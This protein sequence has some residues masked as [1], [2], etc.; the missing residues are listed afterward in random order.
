MVRQLKEGGAASDCFFSSMFGGMSEPPD[1]KVEGLSTQHFG[2][3]NH[4]APAPGNVE[5]NRLP[6]RVGTVCGGE[7]ILYD[8]I[9]ELGTRREEAIALQEKDRVPTTHL[10]ETFILWGDL[11]PKRSAPPESASHRKRNLIM[12]HTIDIQ[13]SAPGA[14]RYARAAV[15]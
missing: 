6:G 8:V 4:G 3:P 7:P 2:V 10:E 1:E 9:D 5:I 15:A 13:P 14:K 12:A 11:D